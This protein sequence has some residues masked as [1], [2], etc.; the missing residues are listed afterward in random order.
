MS[1]VLLM[2][3]APDLLDALQFIFEAKGYT[4]KI[5]SNAGDIFSEISQFCPDILI[6][7]ILLGGEDGRDICKALRKDGQNKDL[8]ILVFSANPNYLHD[9]KS[10]GAD[11]YIEKPF[12]INTLLEKASSLLQLQSPPQVSS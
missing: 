9:Y 4:V 3:D 6:I 5:L 7:D 10:Y 12:D 1:K 11:D 8:R 2:D